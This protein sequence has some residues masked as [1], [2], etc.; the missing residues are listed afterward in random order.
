ML[1]MNGKTQ[2]KEPE[3]DERWR[4]MECA[5]FSHVK[6]EAFPCHETEDRDGFNC[7][8]CYC[9]LY[10]LGR[11]CGGKFDYLPSGAK[12]CSFCLVPHERG[13]YG[14]ITSRIRDTPNP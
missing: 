6:C 10:F 8:F 13:N 3:D 9:P 2:E 7:L 11:D 14:F 12:D 4:G 5:F 1:L